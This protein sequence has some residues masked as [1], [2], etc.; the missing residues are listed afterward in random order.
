MT[1]P[2]AIIGSRGFKALGMVRNLVVGLPAGTVVVSGGA[3]GVDQ[4]VEMA[5]RQRGL[6]CR[7]IRP[8][9]QKYPG[10][11]APLIRNSEIVEAASYLIAF[12][13]GHSTGT[14]FT[15]DLARK[16]GIPVVV[17]Q[18]GKD[19]VVYPGD[20]PISLLPDKDAG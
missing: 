6:E 20:E 8:D 19:P 1:G 5:A 10:K 18:V 2:V 12:W 13:D 17:Y 3:K 9:Y 11:F 16:K 15:V 4:I 14:P 7:I